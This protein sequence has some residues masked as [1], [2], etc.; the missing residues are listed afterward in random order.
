MTFA[1]ATFGVWGARLVQLAIAL[2][3]FGWFDVIVSVLGAT[4]GSGILPVSG[5]HV[6]APAIAVLCRPGVTG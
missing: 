4:A 2:A 1:E 6:A 5:V 3:L